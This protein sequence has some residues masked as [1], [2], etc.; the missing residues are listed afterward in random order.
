MFFVNPSR[1]DGLGGKLKQV[2]LAIL[3]GASH[4]DPSNRG[5][6]IFENCSQLVKLDGCRAFHIH[7]PGQL[8]FD[9]VHHLGLIET[10]KSDVQQLQIKNAW[11]KV[12][13]GY[14]TLSTSARNSCMICT[15]ESLAMVTGEGE[16]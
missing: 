7:I 12:S 4:G 10:N 6:R 15:C 11:K 8:G 5:S 3:H 13:S 2:I 1:L 16:G 9:V 14:L